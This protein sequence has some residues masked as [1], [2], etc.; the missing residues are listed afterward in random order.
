VPPLGKHPITLGKIIFIRRRSSPLLMVKAKDFVTIVFTAE[1]VAWIVI[2]AP[3][4]LY[5]LN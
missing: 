4:I 5:E 3:I 1:Y 2:C